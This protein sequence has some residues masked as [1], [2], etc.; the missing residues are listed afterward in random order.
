MLRS[1]LG[2]MHYKNKSNVQKADIE[3]VVKFLDP[4][5]SSNHYNGEIEFLFNHCQGKYF[6]LFLIKCELCCIKQGLLVR[7]HVANKTVRYK[8]DGLANAAS[9]Q[10]FLLTRN[11]HSSDT[12]VEDY[13]K[14]E[15]GIKLKLVYLIPLYIM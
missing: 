15:Y 2:K 10:T 11:G 6:E 5:I 9:K 12:T 14:K 8:I 7:S 13:Y 4:H 1:P 3:D